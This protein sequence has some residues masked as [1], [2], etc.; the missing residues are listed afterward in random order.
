MRCSR[1]RGPDCLTTR[2]AWFATT[3]TIWICRAMIQCNVT[4]QCGERLL[5]NNVINAVMRTTVAQ[6]H[7]S[8]LGLRLFGHATHAGIGVAR[9]VHRNSGVPLL[10]ACRGCSAIWSR[11]PRTLT[12]STIQTTSSTHRAVRGCGWRSVCGVQRRHRLVAVRGCGSTTGLR[13]ARG[14]NGTNCLA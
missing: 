3:R 14:G 10:S 8:Q 5:L 11:A 12:A 6:G 9:Q 4:S 13:A 1:T 7:D 2:K